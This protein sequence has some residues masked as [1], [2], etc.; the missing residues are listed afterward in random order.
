MGAGRSFLRSLLLLAFVAGVAGLAQAQVNRPPLRSLAPPPGHVRARHVSPQPPRQPQLPP[1]TAHQ[2]GLAAEPAAV[3]RATH[4]EPVA[5]LMGHSGGASCEAGCVACGGYAA[6]YCEVGQTWI[7]VDYLLWWEHG[8]DLPVLV[9]TSAES[10]PRDDAAVEGLPSTRSIF[11]GQ[12]VDDNPLSGGRIQFGHWMDPCQQRGWAVEYIGINQR[13]VGFHATSDDFPILGRPFFN[14][15]LG[16]EDALLLGFPGELE[17]SVTVESD[18]EFQSWAALLVAQRCQT[19]QVR[20]DSLFGY[21]HYGYNESLQVNNDLTFID[22]NGTTTVGTTIVQND[23]FA[24]ENEFHGAEFGLLGQSD[25]GGWNLDLGIRLAIGNMNRAVRIAG[26]SVTTT[27][28]SAPVTTT[29]GLLTQN[30]NIGG[31]SDDEF[32]FIPQFN[33][34]FSWCLTPRTNCRFGYS[35]LYLADVIQPADLIDRSVDLTQQTQTPAGDV[36]PQ[37]TLT[38]TDIWLQGLNFGLDVRF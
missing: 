11:G 36:P 30:S 29:G 33:A 7:T 20:V 13:S 16:E 35:F 12:R 5:A 17:G 6:P 3:Q 8:S 10:T 14:D 31:F 27:P 25:L 15:V 34:G 26:Q 18:A 9:T 28:G 1:A 22:P 21:R 4:S 23:L 2:S 24:V 37:L 19:C 32:T 38:D